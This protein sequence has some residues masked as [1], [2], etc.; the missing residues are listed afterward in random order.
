M[1]HFLK[2]KH[3][4]ALSV[5]ASLQLPLSLQAG[6]VEIA[7]Q[8]LV[9]MGSSDV[10]PNVMFILDNSGSMGWSYTPDWA[11]SS[12]ETLFR[13]P[14]YN[15][16]FY[17]PEISYTPAVTHTG[18]SMGNQ[19]S[20]W[21]GVKNDVTDTGATKG[22]TSNLVGNADYY[23]FVAGEYCTRADLGQCIVSAG[24][25]ATHPF[26]APMR[27]CNSS[28]AATATTVTAI[29]PTANSC[30]AVRVGGYTN[31]RRPSATATI[32]FSGSNSTS[33][34]GITINGRQILS[35]ATGFTTNT[36]TM[37]ANVVT[38]INNCTNAPTGNCTTLGYSAS[39]SGSVVT[40]LSFWGDA[41]VNGASTPVVS[42]TGSMG[43]AITAFARRTP[44]SMT[45]TDIVSTTNSYTEPGRAVK[46]AD[47]TDCAGTVCTYAEEMTNFANW[48]TYYRT[49][50]QS[51]KTAASLAFRGIDS[52]YRVGFIT[53]NS[54]TSNYLAINKFTTGA[55]SQKQAWY[56]RL[57]ATNPG[58][59]TP[60]RSALTRVGRI[61]AGR[62]TGAYGDPV[63]YACQQNFSLLTTDGYWNTDSASAVRDINGNAIGNLDGGSTPRPLFEGPTASSASLADA[64]KYYFDTD[65]RAPAFSNCTGALGNDVC[66]TPDDHPKQGMTTMTLGLGIDGTL[67]YEDRYKDQITG[68]FADLKNGAINWPVPAADSPTAIDDLWHAA[69]NGNGT[70]YSARNPK[71]LRES[72]IK[73]LSEINSVFG[74]GSAAAS[75]SLA[76]VAGD[77][78]QYVASYRTAKWTGNLEARAV[79]LNTLVTSQA[80]TWCA[81]NVAAQSCTP[82]A[83]LETNPNGGFYCKT[84]TSNTNDCDDLG[85]TLGLGGTADACYV[86]VASTC[87]GRLQQQVANN[88]R[89]IFVNQSNTLA[90][91]STSSIGAVNSNEFVN[92]YNNLSQ[93]IDYTN[94]QQTYSN[95]N[96]VARLVDYLRGNK[97]YEN[98][99]SNP[100]PENRLFREREATLGD[101]TQSRP[102]YFKKSVLEYTDPG[103]E[104]YKA[105][106][107]SRQGAVF[108]GANDGMLHAF[109][110]NSGDEMWAFIPS[111]VIKN[112]PKIA[113]R[114]YAIKHKNFVNGSP[115][116][117]DVCIGGCTTAGASWRSILVGGLNGG[118]RG[119]YALDVT[120]PASPSMLWEF[121]A[122]ND[123]A[124][125]YSFG[126]PIVTKLGPTAGALAGRW[127]VVV[128]S[129]YNNGS[130]DND[131]ITP[132][133][134]S[135]NGQGYLFVLDAYT[136]AVLR[137][138]GTGIGT[139]LSPSGL[140]RIAGY[141]TNPF[142]NNLAT[143][144]YGG[145]LEGNLWRFD[146][147]LGTAQR[148]ARLVSP[149]GTPQPITTAP[150]LGT[151]N[152]KRI[153]LVGTGKYLEAS[154][155]TDT[156]VH[157][158][159]AIKDD[160]LTTTITPR[161]LLVQQSLSS[162]GDTRTINTSPVDLSTGLG[163]MID[164][165]AGERVNLDPLLVNGVL[166][167][168]S[169]MPN[170]TSCLGGGYGWFNYFNYK[171]GGTPIPGTNLVSEKMNTP[172][173]GFNVL[174]KDGKPSVSVVGSN[175]PTPRAI[176]QKDVAAKSGG[177][178]R[179]TVLKDNPDGTYGRRSIWRELFR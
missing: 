59:G 26:P 123:S 56:A 107:D 64:A 72:L 120:N 58:G 170:S 174:Y 149:S 108:V 155:I 130:Y 41:N 3:F 145:D 6:H 37:A 83:V 173:V 103:Y 111:P 15:T 42:R 54:P 152:N 171:S 165:P 109:N 85:G 57:Y 69:V 168:P 137:K 31:L 97:T 76:P 117:T 95:S 150:E 65:I 104:A 46:A 167:M 87:T 93:Y 4:L 106:G 126:N 14:S 2:I 158:V 94:V 88:S 60:L 138:I 8:P 141:A 121:T 52:R 140:G 146:I 21:T 17:N 38:R 25:T 112:M 102:A 22:G 16:Q 175:D 23:A 124:M 81:E 99:L 129:G 131:G 34:T 43:V 40:I 113:D 154:D 100:T 92:G 89:N 179:T 24:P 66:G 75:S 156:Q 178:N 176:Q 142:K 101:I 62:E 128:T 30:Q 82:P 79:D 84:P 162:N 71:V 172:A 19:G 32:S 10:L 151:F 28:A 125:G 119:Y 33:V 45:Y 55:T 44:G 127:V 115:L 159:Y 73:G 135:G 136:G 9:N 96:K 78:F 39:R 77:N 67:V 53:I 29:P 163:W 177:S 161:G 147:N 61:Y 35:A 47:R 118:G 50:M 110:A 143:H 20:P 153:V 169:L 139:N 98:R 134:P 36:G 133:N 49:R 70:Y 51:M 148:I 132:N 122:A 86:T 157:S 116:I 11:N 27:W 5:L 18:A 114:D 80:A 144:I 90:Q 1:N 164:F 160:D 74:A 166:L 63:E 48:H 91:F 105:L 68:S 12:N 13:N 7:D